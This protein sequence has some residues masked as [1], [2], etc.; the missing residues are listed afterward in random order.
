MTSFLPLSKKDRFVILLSNTSVLHSWEKFYLWWL[1]GLSYRP[2]EICLAVA[3]LT[4]S[5][6]KA[7]MNVTT[8]TTSAK[9]GFHCPP[10]WSRY[11]VGK[12]LL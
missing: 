1:S 3:R 12:I 2:K 6:H 7:K 9:S 8:Q 10:P 11:P 5:K 4:I